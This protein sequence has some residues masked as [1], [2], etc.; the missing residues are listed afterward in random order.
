MTD[1]TLYKILG[2]KG[3]VFHGGKGRWQLPHGKR[4]GKWMPAV[5]G[6]ITL[7]SNGYHLIPAECLISWLGPTI[8]EAEGRGDQ[9]GDTTKTAFREARVLKR[10]EHWNGRNTRLFAADCAARAL[11][12]WRERYQAKRLKQDVDPRSH[13]AVVAARDFAHGHI[14]AAAGDAAWAAARGAA[15]DAAGAAA[16]AAAGDPA[17]AA[18]GAAAWDAAGDAA[19]AAA[20]AAAWAAAGAAAWDAAGDVAG[21]AEGAAAW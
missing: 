2:D 18:A 3:A 17:R 6:E 13:A 9:Q 19:R 1:T 15:R 7:C 16:R 5:T 14:S 12:R 10:L 8:Y 21:D 20:G 11:N 4:P